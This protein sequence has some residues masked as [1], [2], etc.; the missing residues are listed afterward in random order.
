MGG[1]HVLA[2]TTS[3]LDQ[4]DGVTRPCSV[5][6][7]VRSVGALAVVNVTDNGV[8]GASLARGHGMVGLADRLRGV[9]GSLAVS[10]PAG[11]PTQLTA[12]LPQV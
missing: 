1:V 3:P 10:S 6:V 11:G 4:T 2:A 9:D 8:G 12:T 7:E 5:S